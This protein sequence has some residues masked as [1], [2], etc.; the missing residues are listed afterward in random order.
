[1]LNSAVRLAT[2]VFTAVA[3][4]SCGG[5]G[6]IAGDSNEFSVFPDEVGFTD[7]EIRTTN[8]ESCIGVRGAQTVFT[9]VGGQAPFRIVNPN[10]QYLSVDKTEATGK[11]PKFT[12]TLTGGCGDPL[13]IL[14]LDYHSQSASVEIVVE[15]EVEESSTPATP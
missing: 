14:V 7:N 3:L 9:I 1:M 4:V 5:G 6:D 11:D 8:K 13:T 2:G 15:R 12:M 10:P